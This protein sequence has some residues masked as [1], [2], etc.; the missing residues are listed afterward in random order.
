[1]HFLRKRAEI[2]APTIFSFV[3]GSN[4]VSVL[5]A[6]PLDPPCSAIG[7]RYTISPFI[8]QVL[9]GIALY[10]RPQIR[11]IAAKQ[12][13]REGASQLK[14]P[15]GGYRAI[16]GHRSYGYYGIANRGLMSH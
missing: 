12:G 11:S 10:P 6:Q 3:D 1:M 14:L 5:V 2:W 16:G 8:F 4:I 13:K 15:S 7:Y 9:Q